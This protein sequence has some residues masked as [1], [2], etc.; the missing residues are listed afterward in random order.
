MILLT[1]QSSLELTEPYLKAAQSR[2]LSKRLEVD[3]TATTSRISCNKY[4]YHLTNYFELLADSFKP[5]HIDL[6][7]PWMAVHTLIK[8]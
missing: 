4:M 7:L 1:H 5:T 2:V 8:V 3:L 6:Q